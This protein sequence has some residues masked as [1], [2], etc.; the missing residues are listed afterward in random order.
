MDLDLDLN[1]DLSFAPGLFLMKVVVL[2]E[3][4]TFGGAERQACVLAGE[5]KRRGH[6]VC[7][8]TYHR[9]DFYRSLLERE[10]VEHRFLGGRGKVSWA[11]NVRRFLRSHG[12]DVVLAFL[13]GPSAYAE[14]AGLPRRPWGLVVCERS[15]GSLNRSRLKTY[16]H[17]FADYVTFNSHAARIAI[18]KAHPE[19]SSKLI[20][21]YNA[22]QLDA[23]GVGGEG[24]ATKGEIRLI[25]P[26]RLDRNKN[27]HG[28]LSAVRALRDSAPCIRLHVDWYG[29]QTTDPG[30]LRETQDGIA[31]LDLAGVFRLHPPSGNIHDVMARADAV[32]LASYYEG[33]PN[34][35]CEGMM[36]GKPILMS[37]VCDARSL[38]QEGTNGF[39]FN[40][41]S[42]ESIADAFGKFARLSHE[43]RSRMGG[44]SRVKAETLFNVGLVTDHYLRVLEAAAR[45]KAL[46]LE[47]WPPEGFADDRA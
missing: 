45:R 21:I 27:P 42:P 23:P 40:P 22:V 11:V 29:D 36:L 39:L 35:V 33:L 10:D 32:L 8:V 44:A 9:D 6:Q 16:L 13:S 7:V 38:V 5:F 26:A 30:V 15:A 34:A 3:S 41:C 4:L 24:R 43:E 25:V 47:H 31:S 20:T 28:L 14:L 12:Q 17:T 18:G 37:D 2:V 19:L 46:S 1:L